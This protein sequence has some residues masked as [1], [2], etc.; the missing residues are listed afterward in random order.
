MLRIKIVEGTFDDTEGGRGTTYTWNGRIHSIR[1]CLTFGVGYEIIE[2]KSGIEK[3]KSNTIYVVKQPRLLGT[4]VVLFHELSHWIVRK[5]GFEQVGRGKTL[6]RW[7]DKHIRF[8]FKRGSM[9]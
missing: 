1:G 9:R 2:Y 7:I 4:L 3:L 5:V 6:H 8:N